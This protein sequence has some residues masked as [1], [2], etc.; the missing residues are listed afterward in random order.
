MSS[1]VLNS[2]R[3]LGGVFRSARTAVHDPPANC[4]SNQF[5]LSALTGALIR[6]LS[7]CNSSAT[8]CACS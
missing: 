7:F 4:V 3:P 5:F 8:P 1:L 6:L 2:D